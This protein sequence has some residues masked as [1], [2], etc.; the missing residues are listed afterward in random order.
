MNINYYLKDNKKII[1]SVNIIIRY[2]GKRFK[3]AT[4]ESIEVKFWNGRRLDEKKA[5]PDATLINLRLER[6]ESRIRAVFEPHI[7]VG[8][9]PDLND[10][11][12]AISE[13]GKSNSATEPSNYLLPFFK[14][15]YNDATYELSTWKKYNTAYNPC[16]RLIILFLKKNF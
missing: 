4:G 1:T 12:A 6:I 15:Y 13:P 10:L 9:I 11:R 8:T 16:G 3:I 7:L 14:K 2:K 5:C